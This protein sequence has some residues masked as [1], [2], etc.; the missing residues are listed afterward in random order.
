MKVLLISNIFIFIL[1]SFNCERN[2]LYDT[3]RDE[4]NAVSV[5]D[6]TSKSITAFS[7]IS[8]VVSG[9]ID[10]GSYAITVSVPY[11]T[12]I[13]ALIATFA[14]TGVSVYVGPVSQTSGATINDFTNP[15]VYT[16]FA[17]D[18]SEQDYTVTVT[19]NPGTPYEIKHETGSA[20]A[21]FGGDNRVVGGPRD[22]GD[23]QSVFIDTNIILES[24]SLFF[25]GRFDYYELPE[26]MG[27]GVTLTLNIRDSIGNILK[28]VQ[29]VVPASYNGGWV[30]W[31]GIDFNVAQDTTLIFTAYL[32]GAYDTDQYTTSINGESPGT[33]AGG[34]RY[35]KVGTGDA[36]MELWSG[37]APDTWDLYFWLQGTAP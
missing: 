22:I 25:S 34:S 36:D 16:V 17:G 15:V 2:D 23:G 21:W 28:T 7:F 30:T 32:V 1:F 8:P 33:Y 27:H 4:K 20:L 18:G 12:D 10:E 31:T 5:E 35:S 9:T 13:T 37:W 26:G 24:F 19:V 14:T 29:V 3:A 6:V 11:G